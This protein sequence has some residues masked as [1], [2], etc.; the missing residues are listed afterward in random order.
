M[1]GAIIDMQHDLGWV[2]ARLCT[3]KPQLC[4]GL[5]EA[6]VSRSETPPGRRGVEAA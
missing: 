3:E 1:P 6:G 2:S 5:M 4:E